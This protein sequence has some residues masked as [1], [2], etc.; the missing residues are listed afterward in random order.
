MV[1][2]KGGERRRDESWG[3]EDTEPEVS[4]AEAADAAIQTI[5]ELTGKNPI[6]ATAVKP[7]EEGWLIEVE[8]V[9]ES[10]IPS[11]ADVLALYEVDLDLDATL[12]S[13]SRIRRYSRGSALNSKPGGRQ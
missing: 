7:T 13:Y 5:G 1:A 12:V 9:E 2:G 11:S 8:V 3:S 4:A 10:R 6:G